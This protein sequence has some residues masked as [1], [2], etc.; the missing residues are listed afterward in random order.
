MSKS[1]LVVADEHDNLSIEKANNI[2]S[3]LDAK[4]E[5]VRFLC[6]LGTEHEIHRQQAVDEA[7][8]A[9]ERDTS[10]IFDSDAQV[11]CNVIATDDVADWIISACKQK[12]YDFVI[13]TG[14]RTDGDVHTSLDRNLMQKLPCAMFI[15][16]DRKWKSKKVIL[17][18]VDLSTNVKLRKDYNNIV[19]KWTAMLADAFNYDVHIVYSIPIA[20]PLLELDIVEK[21]EVQQKKQPEAEKNT[22]SLITDFNLDH[23]HTHIT[24]GPADKN[25]P[26]I[27]NKLKADLVVMGCVGKKGLKELVF[28]K[29]AENTLHNIRTDILV[30]RGRRAK[31]RK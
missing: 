23:A 21:Q 22:L 8:Q 14:R 24:A 25:I 7:R 5:I 4:I 29:I 6:N 18:A 27:A 2:A 11:I 15:V 20:R 30:C 12:Q 16:S 19:L 17:A 1:I 26:S 13:K 28:G 3:S 10:S 9:L 31:T